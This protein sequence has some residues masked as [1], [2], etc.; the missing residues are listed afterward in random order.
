MGY[1]RA[2]A[3]AATEAVAAVG[4]AAAAAAA[5][6]PV[7]GECSRRRAATVPSC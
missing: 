7:T 5:L 6:S 2:Q 3:Y 4:A 1:H